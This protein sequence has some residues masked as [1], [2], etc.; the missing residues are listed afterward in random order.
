MHQKNYLYTSTD[1]MLKSE[2]QSLLKAISCYEFILSTV[3]W[4]DILVKANIVSKTLQGIKTN[5]SATENLLIGLIVFFEEYQNIGFKKTKLE[6]NILAKSV[7]I[8]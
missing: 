7:E 6:A 2:S 4:D 1:G 5:L 8:P 3:I